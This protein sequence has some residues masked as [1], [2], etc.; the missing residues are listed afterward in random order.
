MIRIGRVALCIVVCVLGGALAATAPA[1]VAFADG[2]DASVTWS[3]QPADESG[4]DG[5]SW[6]E[7]TLDP[8]EH[9]VEHLAL[10]NLSASTVTFAIKAADGYLTS[11]GRFNMLPSETKSVGAGTWIEPPGTVEVAA[12]ATQIVAFTITVPDDATPG[13]HAAGIAATVQSAGSNG[14]GAQIAIESRVGFPIMTRVTGELKPS[15]VVESVRI[16]YTMAWSPFSPGQLTAIYRL[17]NDGNV[18]IQAVPVVSS[19][20]QTSR[21][22][23]EAPAIEAPAWPEPR[24]QRDGARGLADLLLDSPDHHRP[25]R[26]HTRRRAANFRYCGS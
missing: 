23:P 16:D 14:D 8:G 7:Q 1:P 17:V 5:R 13:D 26:R 19:Q 22:D 25:D 11:T 6:I 9:V 15:L 20:G 4:P 21:V 18:R 10:R 24:G 2:E 12:G 3:V